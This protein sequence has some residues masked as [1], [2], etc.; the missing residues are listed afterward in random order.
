MVAYPPTTPM[1]WIGR[2]KNG[3]EE[4]PH[5]NGRFL[6]TLKDNEDPQS[7][8]LDWATCTPR[9]RSL[10]LLTTI[11]VPDYSGTRMKQNG[12]TQKGLRQHGYGPLRGKFCYSTKPATQKQV[13]S[14]ESE[15]GKKKN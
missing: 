3:E 4:A 8:N 1:Q 15:V 12:L 10:H 5:C 11:V 13:K 6:N 14:T 7:G 9:A 2:K